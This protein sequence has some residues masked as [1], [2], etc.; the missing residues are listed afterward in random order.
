MMSNLHIKK[1]V[2]LAAGFGSRMNLH[3][4]GRPKVLLDF[5]GQP[6]ILYAIRAL[7]RAGITNIGVVVGHRAEV[8]ERTL[9]IPG[10]IN[11]NLEYIYNAHFYG[12]N[13]TS[14]LAARDWLEEEPF[15][16]CMGDHVMDGRLV[17]RLLR[18]PSIHETLCVDRIPR[19]HIDLDEATKVR[20]DPYGFIKR[21]GKGLG[22][23]DAIDTGVF[24]LTERFMEN[25]TVLMSQNGMDLEISDVIQDVVDSGESFA[26]CDV[27][28]LFW[29]DLD[30]RDDIRSIIS[31]GGEWSLDTM[32]SSPD[33]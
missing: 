13:A 20:T 12:G 2:V 19:H 14:V 9:E 32:A 16:L 4:E 11:I 30:T 10:T 18:M 21:I 5:G 24:L 27:T 22:E 25:A 1:G 29:A 31:G 7:V 8:V 23:W 3:S 28:G 6:L 26:T 33:T 15:V 17:S